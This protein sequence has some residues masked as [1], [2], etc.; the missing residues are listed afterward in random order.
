MM[1]QIK[2]SI[3]HYWTEIFVQVDVN[4]TC[5]LWW[6]SITLLNHVKRSSCKSIVYQQNL[7]FDGLLFLRSFFPRIFKTSSS[8]LT[9][10]SERRMQLNDYL[11]PLLVRPSVSVRWFF[12]C[13]P[14][15]SH[16]YFLYWF[17]GREDRCTSAKVLFI[18]IFFVPL[19]FYPF[20]VNNERKEYTHL[21]HFLPT[22]ASNENLWITMMNYSTFHTLVLTTKTRC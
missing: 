2:L 4:L 6:R 1:T 3:E 14:V 19:I 18:V 11:T 13:F 10:Y 21:D 15:N 17:R 5:P 16:S 22:S 8:R 9:I 20:L 12:K 7:A